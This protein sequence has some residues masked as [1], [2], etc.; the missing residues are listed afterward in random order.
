MTSVTKDF[1]IGEKKKREINWQV[2]EIPKH[3]FRCH[4]VTKNFSQKKKS[5]KR[6][7][8]TFVSESLQSQ[9]IHKQ[10]SLW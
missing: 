7:F 2:C 6:K 8:A 5:C 3:K 1:E 10:K 4:N 9:K